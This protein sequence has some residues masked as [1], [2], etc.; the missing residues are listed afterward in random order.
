MLAK[1]RR[2]PFPEFMFATSVLLPDRCAGVDVR[3]PP[4]VIGNLPSVEA[5]TAD[6]STD[7]QGFGKHWIAK[8]KADLFRWGVIERVSALI[9]SAVFLVIAPG[10]IAGLVPWWI[11]HWKVEPPLFGVYVLRVG[12]AGLITLGLLALLDSFTR[13]AMQGV[14]TP[15]PTYPTRYLVVVGLYRYVRNP[16]YIAVVS[17]ILGQALLLGNVAL[18]EY[19]GLMWAL[20]HIFVLAYEEPKLRRSFGH[21]YEMYCAAVPRWFPRFTAWSGH[22]NGNA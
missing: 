21:D 10:T 20:F 5:G 9:G 15:S 16:M 19:G 17:T 7:C 1:L 18:L 12:G 8:R 13:F 14:G 6:Q 3:I 2:P 22:G 4:S 11:S